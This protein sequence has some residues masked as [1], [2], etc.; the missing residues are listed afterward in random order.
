MSDQLSIPSELGVVTISRDAVAQIV[1][2]TAAE[3]YG[4]VGLEPSN[5]AGKLLRRDG[6]EIEPRNGGVAIT[7][8]V[9]IE[10]GLNLAEV[11]ATVRSRVAYEVRRIAGLQVDSVEVHIEK[12]RRSA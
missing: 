10:R 8:R 6:V 2:H 3:C 7:L 5:L 1:E 4:V 9:A 11:A 12:V